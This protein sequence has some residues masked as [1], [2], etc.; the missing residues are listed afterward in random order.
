[1]LGITLFLAASSSE[2]Q[3]K[4]ITSADAEVRFSAQ[5]QVKTKKKVIASAVVRFSGQKKLF[6]QT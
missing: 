6:T 1:M 5:I 4:I 2:D 3:N